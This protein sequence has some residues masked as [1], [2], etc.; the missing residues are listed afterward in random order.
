MFD[1]ETIR[2]VSKERSQLASS[3]WNSY[4]CALEK[5]GLSPTSRNVISDDSEYIVSKCL[6]PENLEWPMS[7][8]RSG[9]VMGA[10]QSG[11]TASM[12]AVISKCL[13]RDID[14]VVVLAGTITNLWRQTLDRVSAQLAFSQNS[15]L[16]P[17]SHSLTET[18]HGGLSDL[19]K[20]PPK[21]ML[22]RMI[23]EREPLV[24]VVMKNGEHLY[25]LSSQLK[26]MLFPLFDE[27]ERD[28]NMLVID[29]EADDGSI[30]DSRVEQNLD[31]RFAH[32]KQIPRHIVDLWSD[33]RDAPNTAHSRLFVNYLAYTA[34]PQA[35]FLQEEMN[36]LAPNAFVAAL[37]TPFDTGELT[38]RQITYLEPNGYKNFYTGG[39]VFYSTFPKTKGL[40]V[41]R[42][43]EIPEPSDHGMNCRC[44]KVQ[45]ATR[46]FLVA[47][48]IRFLR[49]NSQLDLVSI[50][51]E[52]F[53]S[54][55]QAIAASPLTHTMLIHP[56]AE[57]ETHQTS[58]MQLMSWGNEVD[59]NNLKNRLES[60]TR[61]LDLDAIKSD[62][63]KHPEFW[64][65]WIKEFS[66]TSESVN[67]R[68]NDHSNM[69]TF[70]NLDWEEIRSFIIESLVPAVSI[71]VINSDENSDDRP[72]FTP[73]KIEDGWKIAPNFLT[74][75]ISGNVMSRGITLAGLTTTLFMRHA[76]EPAS[77]TQMQM[78]RWFGYR[79]KE[80][81][82]TRVFLPEDQLNLFTQYHEADSFLRN[83]IITAMNQ[84][85][86]I[87]PLPTV[88][89]GLN[90]IA[91]AKIAGVSKMALSPGHYPFIRL[92]NDSSKIDQNIS[93]AV[94]LLSDDFSD[95]KVGNK[96]FGAIRNTP[97]NMIQL[98]EF[99]E[100]LRFSQYQPMPDLVTSTRWKSITAQF[101]TSAVENNP[102]F[103]LF[104]PPEFT[105]D[106]L[107]VSPRQCPYNIAAYL[108]LWNA[109]T[110]HHLSGFVST[111]NPDLPW[112]KVDLNLKK[113]Q[114]PEFWVGIRFGRGPVL[115]NNHYDSK[116][117]F[118]ID[119][120]L[121]D[122]KIIAGMLDSTWGS[123]NPGEDGY[124]GDQFFDYHHHGKHSLLPPINSGTTEARPPGAPGLVLLHIVHREN[125]NP[126][127][128]VGLAIPEGGPDQI[129]SR[130]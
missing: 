53:D 24:F 64:I 118:P 107:Q 110:S 3:W 31:Q 90:H 10:V 55:E 124:K 26:K 84:N 41:T 92:V 13:D 52:V 78:Q 42:E 28:F 11:K 46:C 40:T 35:N 91:T 112:R 7:R 85:S 16:F 43:P 127:L 129:A 80:I 93:H 117:N 103:P 115:K 27:F 87:A 88:L 50:K 89:E 73:V 29:D 56:G 5:E 45:E 61:I 96:L 58:A 15:K 38:P 49:S 79:G 20:L 105:K 128:A 12:L 17:G 70:T 75:F 130:K 108:R 72:Q 95:L 51:S 57:M 48:A 1:H 111:E 71:S 82:V 101:S 106:C 122:R 8:Y 100:N 6:L 67:T 39:E 63:E 77:D 44:R 114:L 66:D 22:R 4:L 18:S 104:N 109:A 86:G 47:G 94:E 74:I 116:G 59:L 30:L 21:Q 37:R 119:I 62:I 69:R 36:P 83:Q 33:R 54:K 97:I 98:A 19:Y 113:N 25:S 65:K 2:Q 32:L 14:V 121:M 99:L 126:V 120:P 68:F 102:A 60:N 34:T 23:N 125:A 81:D 123:R 9:L 76:N